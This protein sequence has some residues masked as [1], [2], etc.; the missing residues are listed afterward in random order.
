[1][2]HLSA[3]SEF[4]AIK[5]EIEK[6]SRQIAFVARALE[7]DPSALSVSVSVPCPPMAKQP[8]GD[9]CIESGHW[10][11]A[12]QIAT[13]ISRYCVAK[14]KLERAQQIDACASNPKS[15]ETKRD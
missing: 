13:L 10:P 5:N 12:D 7:V 14:S 3:R 8:L 6:L 15:R 1:M 2:D 11:S 9:Y 4:E